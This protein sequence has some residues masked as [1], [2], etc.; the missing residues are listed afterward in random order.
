MYLPATA[1]QMLAMDMLAFDKMSKS[2]RRKQS[3]PIRVS[4]SA[5]ND[6]TAEGGAPFPNNGQSE[7]VVNGHTEEQ[8]V[9]DS[10]M[11]EQLPVGKVNGRNP[12]LDS[13]KN[14]DS[15][16]GEKMVLDPKEN[17]NENF[18]TKYHRL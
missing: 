2:N 9:S 14:M 5:E 8:N 6:P 13:D 16:D 15:P 12:H 4:Y 11:E 1:S 7:E 10:E 18:P 3:K 17:N